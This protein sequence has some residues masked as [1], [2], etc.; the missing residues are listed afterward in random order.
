MSK[1]NG[2]AIHGDMLRP[3]NPAYAGLPQEVEKQF[4][5]VCELQGRTGQQF[6][7]PGRMKKHFLRW[8]AV[9]IRHRKGDFRNSAS[10]WASLK[11]VAQFVFDQHCRLRGQPNKTLVWNE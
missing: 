9:L 6:R 7:I 3:S 5:T 8:R 11:E 2:K 10:E 4:L 1:S